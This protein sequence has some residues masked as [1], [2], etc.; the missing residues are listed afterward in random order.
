M[1][2]RF[3]GSSKDGNIQDQEKS[4][5]GLR[6]ELKGPALVLRS[7]DLCNCGREVV[8]AV[9]ELSKAPH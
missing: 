2:L 5:S 1:F 7:H 6:P 9:A 4:W 3:I 8:V